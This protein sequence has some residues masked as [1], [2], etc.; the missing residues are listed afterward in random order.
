MATISTGESNYSTALVCEMAGV[1]DLDALRAELVEKDNQLAEKAHKLVLAGL[2]G[3]S[4]LEENQQ[5]RQDL[6]VLKEDETALQE[7]GNYPLIDN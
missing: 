1:L 2:A 7:V 6:K 5:L 3:K 4:L